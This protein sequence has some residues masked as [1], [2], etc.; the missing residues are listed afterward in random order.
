MGKCEFC[1][2]NDFLGAT[3]LLGARRVQLETGGKVKRLEA[4]IFCDDMDEQPELHI[5]ISDYG[6]EETIAELNIPISVCPRCG[7][8][9]KSK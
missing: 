5:G 3:K 4:W 2:E 6:D 1:R 8:E 7:R 9:L